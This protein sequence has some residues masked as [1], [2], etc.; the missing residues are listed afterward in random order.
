MKQSSTTTFRLGIRQRFSLLIV[1]AALSFFGYVW[2]GGT[3][4]NAVNIASDDPPPPT[5]AQDK[6]YSRF[7]HTNAYHSRM[8]CLLCHRRDTN[9]PRVG[10]PGK[11]GHTPCIGCHQL[12]FS[13]N[14]SPICTI[15]H[16]NAQTGAMKGFPGLRS[17]GRK[18]DHNRHG[19]VNCSVC[20]K[21]AQRGV[22]F[23]IP[24]GPNA[25]ATCFQCHSAS[26]PMTMSS[27]NVCHQLGRLVRT[28][29]NAAAYRINFSHT[30]HVQAG[31]NCASCHSVR[32]GGTG[33]Q[34]SKP[35]ASMHFAPQNKASCAACHNGQRAF[36]T[37]DFANCKRCHIGNSFKF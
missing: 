11:T 29:A 35:L 22:A 30:R 23:S 16:T 2:A 6:D 17:F 14:S 27:C 32:A 37:N 20:H 8:P 34:V 15:C 31:L 19:R 21:S 12:Q 13:D 25:H 18:F 4:I 9:S 36:G 24:S 3:N 5:Q 26:Q 1:L 33:Q 7:T 28:S 10:F